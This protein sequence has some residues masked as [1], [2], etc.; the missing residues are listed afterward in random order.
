MWHLLAQPW[1]RMTN[2]I[3]HVHSWYNGPL[4]CY[5]AGAIPCI[6]AIR[7]SC[8]YGWLLKIDHC[9]N[10]SSLVLGHV[11]SFAGIC[12]CKWCGVE[13]ACE[14]N[15]LHLTLSSVICCSV[16]HC[17]SSQ[18]RMVESYVCVWAYMR[19]QLALDCC[20]LDAWPPPNCQD[21]I[22]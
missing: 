13:V 10:V 2:P 18:Q 14:F 12:F 3:T 21:C 20:V 17:L 22:L 9:V 15:H 19:L 6:Y 8:D 11:A 4:C 7:N 1:M 16:L 5:E